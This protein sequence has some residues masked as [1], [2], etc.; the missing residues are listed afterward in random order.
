MNNVEKYA[1]SLLISSPVCSVRDP[2]YR[3]VVLVAQ[4]S[5]QGSWGMVLNRPSR[6]LSISDVMSSAGIESDNS[7]KIFLGGPVEPSRVHVV[8][9]LDW[10][11][12]STLRVTDNI[13]ITGDKT[14]LA[15]LACNDG[16]KHY[17]VGIGLTVWVA[18]Q[19]EKEVREAN[20]KWVIS[21]STLDGAFYKDGTL[22]WESCIND[23]VNRAVS[24][25][26]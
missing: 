19:I 10:E 3:S 18:G 4:H 8:H 7:E 20:V 23:F 1:G 12:E 21:D 6:R 2:Y 25:Y 22:Q 9:S 16:P 5:A 17:R 11:S 15:A 24:R 26:F 13:G 14:I